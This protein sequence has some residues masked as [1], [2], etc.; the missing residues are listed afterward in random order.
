MRMIVM[1]M[2]AAA[3]FVACAQGPAG[4]KGPAERMGQPPS[5]EPVVRM[6]INP[7]TA[8]KLGVTP[9]QSARLKALNAAH[10]EAM[11]AL[12]AK[13]RS[14]MTRQAGLLAAENLDEKAIMAAFDESWATRKEIARLQMKLLIDVRGILSHEQLDKARK[15]MRENFGPR[16]AQP[17]G[18]EAK[19]RPPK[20]TEAEKPAKD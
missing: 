3:A 8:E 1:V 7:K 6:A 15:V 5:I 11:K 20:A 12:R 17:L 4:R 13:T 16:K 14:E 2:A 18:G 19:K 10:A 9:E